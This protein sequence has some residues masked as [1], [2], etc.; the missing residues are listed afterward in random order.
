M[1]QQEAQEYLDAH[2]VTVTLS[3]GAW[4]MCWQHGAIQLGGQESDEKK[5][6]VASAILVYRYLNGEGIQQSVQAARDY[7]C[8]D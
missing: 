2:G 7:L 1:T 6:Y 4:S 5:A 3:E 8:G